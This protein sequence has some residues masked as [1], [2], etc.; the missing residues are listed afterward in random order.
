MCFTFYLEIDGQQKEELGQVS[1]HL[2]GS[3]LRAKFFRD[4]VEDVANAD[5]RVATS[6]MDSYLDFVFDVSSWPV[7]PATSR[8]RGKLMSQLVS[9]AV[10]CGQFPSGTVRLEDHWLCEM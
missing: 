8:A 1:C 7:A 3:G 9:L 2:S 10:S 5:V 6:R 4:L